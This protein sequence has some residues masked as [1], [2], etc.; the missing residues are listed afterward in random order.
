MRKT[1]ES[2]HLN[3]DIEYKHQDHGLT[4]L[5]LAVKY[6]QME[7]A[8]YLIAKGANINALN[9][10]KQSILFNACYDGFLAGVILLLS[11]KADVN[12]QD[13]RGWTPLMIAAYQ[14]HEDIVSH[15]IVE[16]KADV[17]VL[18]RFGKKAQDRAKT[19]A[20]FYLITSAGIEKRMRDASNNKEG[21][22][23]SQELS[24][25]LR[26]F[27]P[28]TPKTNRKRQSLAGKS[29]SRCTSS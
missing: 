18:D 25:T 26:S 9:K 19:S 12:Q 29:R 22:K 15:L 28:A 23:T 14:G 13:S 16:A 4:L 2:Q 17:S 27:K 21:T 24:L 20:I 10:A 3:L 1:L 6:R 5:A 8:S 7:T 11:H